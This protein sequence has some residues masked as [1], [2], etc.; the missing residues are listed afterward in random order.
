VRCGAVIPIRPGQWERLSATA[1]AVE[2]AGWDYVFSDEGPYAGNNDSVAAALYMAT[3]TERINVG[4]SVAITYF[5]HAYNSAS[6][7][8]I[9]NEVSSGRMVLGLGCSHPAI[10]NPLGIEM[11]K[12]VTEMR[13]YIVDVRSHL[14]DDDQSPI[15]LAALRP[16]MARLAGEIATAVNFHMNPLASFAQ[17]VE[18]VREGERRS[19]R[20]DRCTIALYARILMYDDLEEARRLGRETLLAYCGLQTYQ[21][22]YANAGFD[23]EMRGLAAALDTD[24][25]GAAA[26]AISNELLDDVLV[27]GPAERCREQLER[28]RAAGVDVVLFAPPITSAE[29]RIDR[30]FA[31]LV[32]EFAGYE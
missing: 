8:S 18:A 30:L 22:L 21:E 11:P 25:T 24:D 7:V 28:F 20:S 12:P 16:P 4:S 5:R 23:A 2:A 17:V 6:L 10:N 1:R 3:A 31:P 13:A 32:A 29:A 19:E 15:W 27:L 9:I 14:G 26:R